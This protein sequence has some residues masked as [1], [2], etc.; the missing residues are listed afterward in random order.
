MKPFPV[1]RKAF[2]TRLKKGDCT[3]RNGTGAYRYLGTLAKG[4]RTMGN[5][6]Q[7]TGQFGKKREGFFPRVVA[8]TV[9]SGKNYRPVTH[10]LPLGT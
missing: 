2:R 7:D 1:E 8:L 5:N 3:Q 10:S 9:F 4:E 6:H